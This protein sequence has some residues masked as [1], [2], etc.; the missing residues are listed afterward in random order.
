M[1]KKVSVLQ[2]LLVVCVPKGL[3]RYPVLL[4]VPLTTQ[5]GEWVN[6]N[7][8][9]YPQ[10]AAGVGGISQ[11]SAALLDQIRSVDVRRVISYLGSLTSEEYEP[12][13]RGL[14]QILEL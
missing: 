9:L 14:Q 7:P 2:L 4:V 1:S 13:K 10:L 6:E 5:I 12:V 11:A 3:V 8:R